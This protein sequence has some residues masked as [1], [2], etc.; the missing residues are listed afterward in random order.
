MLA[1]HAGAAVALVLSQLV[2]WHFAGAGY[3]WPE[4][5]LLPVAL[6]LAIHAWVELVVARVPAARPDTRAVAIHAGAAACLAVFLTA[7]WAV[8][9][10][11]YFWPGWAILGLAIAL[12]MHALVSSAR[13]RTRRSCAIQ[14]HN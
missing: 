12:G 6:V 3:F 2:I 8:T 4:W 13:K 1:Y 5:V 11:G 7:V 9:D 14:L 10:S